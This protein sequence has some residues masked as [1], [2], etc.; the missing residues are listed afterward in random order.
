V[1]CKSLKDNDRPF[2]PQFD[3]IINEAVAQFLLYERLRDKVPALIGFV[4]ET[5]NSK[6]EIFNVQLVMERIKGKRLSDCEDH[7]VPKKKVLQTLAEFHLIRLMSSIEHND[8]H[9]GNILVPWLSP[10]KLLVSS[11]RCFFIDMP[12]TC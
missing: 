5:D 4:I 9:P 12:W 2:E 6:V 10:L 7:E 3:S 8:I 1:A 11:P